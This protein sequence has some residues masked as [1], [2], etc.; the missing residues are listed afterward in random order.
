MWRIPTDLPLRSLSVG[1]G[2]LCDVGGTVQLGIF[3]DNDQRAL[4]LELSVDQIR[5]KFGYGAI[6]KA[7]MLDCDLVTD[8]MFSEEDLLPFKR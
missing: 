3:D 4:Q 8:K 5:K 2:G 6:K 1:V 7:S